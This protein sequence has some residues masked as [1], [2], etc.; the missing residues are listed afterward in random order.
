MPLLILDFTYLTQVTLTW[1][2]RYNYLTTKQQ[3]LLVSICEWITCSRSP[4]TVTIS[5]E[6]LQT[7]RPTPRITKRLR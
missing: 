1:H 2:H 6:E 5:N 7:H 3:S 4:Y